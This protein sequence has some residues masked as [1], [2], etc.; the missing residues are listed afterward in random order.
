MKRL[1][2]SILNIEKGGLP[3]V[4]PEELIRNY[5]AFVAS[6]VQPEDPSHLK[7]YHWVEAHFRQFK[8]MPSI[9]LLAERAIKEGD[10]AVVV[11]LKEIAP[12]PAYQRSDYLAL[13]KEKFEQQSQE[14][15]RDVL[16]KAWQVVSSG[17][18]TGKGKE[19]KE[20]KGM[21]GALEYLSSE[22]RQFRI[23]TSGIK[24]EGQILAMGERNEVMEAYEKRKKDPASNLGMFTFLDKVDD[25]FRGIKLGE[26]FIIAAYVAQ[27]KTTMAYNLAYNGVIQGLNGLYVPLEM[28]FAEMRELFYALHMSHP[29]WYDHPKYRNLAGKVSYEKVRYGELTPMEEEFFGAASEDL[30]NRDAFGRFRVFQPTEALTPSRLEMEAIDYQ[31]ELTQMGKTLDFIVVDYMGLMVPDRADRYGEFNLDL[32]TTIK[33]L[34][35]LAL[36]F[37]NG[38]GLRMISP[39]QVNRDGWKEAAKAEGVYRLTALSSANESERSADGVISL[40]MSDEMRKS[41]LMKL[42]CLKNRRGPMFP[43]FEACVDFTS[44]RIQ[45][46]IQDKT[47]AA[48]GDEMSINNIALEATS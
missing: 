14:Q 26:L 4:P 3:T 35:T 44:M 30:A 23:R 17:L 13:L 31:A 19:A 38:R 34:K 20:L 18:K 9:V 25:V 47:T 32:N 12:Q 46:S 27:G 22:T 11:Q 45:D 7:I 2:R 1:F 33:K 42:T 43:P 8:E 24:T 10:E 41:G 5:R 37:N 36:T 48:P 28:N 15:F 39:F 16:G 40:F 21:P 6:T 29:D